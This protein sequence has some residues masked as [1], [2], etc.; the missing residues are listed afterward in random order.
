MYQTYNV[1]IHLV[2]IEHYKKWN[3]PS[4][5]NKIFGQVI[6]KES[7]IKDMCTFFYWGAWLSAAARPG[8]TYS[9][10]HNWPH[11][12]LAG[13]EPTPAVISW[14][15]ISVLVLWVGL[16]TT[17]YL[18][19]QLSYEDDDITHKGKPLT[20]QDLESG[21][22]RPTQQLCY[23]FFVL[24]MIAFLIQVLSGVASAIDF[25]Q[26]NGKIGGYNT[27]SFLKLFPYQVL[28]SYHAIFQI[29]WFFVAWV[30]TTIW[31]LPR[32]SR[33]I[34]YGQTFLIN[35][36]FFGCLI[37]AVGGAVGIPLGQSGYLTGSMAYYFGS[38]RLGIYGV[39]TY[40]S[41]YIISWICIMDI[42]IISRYLC[43]Y[44][45]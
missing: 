8:E 40:V 28:R 21:I 4:N 43:I 5:G 23:K 19:G 6:E 38:Q 14:S 25:V 12:S 33:K 20:T 30:G 17:L 42:N 26:V 2:V 37:V 24:S 35:L 41:K 7:E 34:P 31:F 10:T 11:E 39:R 36:L 29:Y 32:F 9:Y 1:Y 15:A 27:V 45:N 3:D 22:V 13:N 16:M 18:W 44:Y